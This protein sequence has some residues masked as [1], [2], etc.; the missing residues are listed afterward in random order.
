MSDPTPAPDSQD[1]PELPETLPSPVRPEPELGG[2]D[3]RDL[4]E[5]G[6]QARTNKTPWQ[7]P[8]PEELSRLLPQY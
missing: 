7:P 8:S 3:P 4:I 5:G 6:L 2:L 1:F